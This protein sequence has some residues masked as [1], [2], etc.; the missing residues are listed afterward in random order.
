MLEA[1]RA[2]DEGAF[3]DLVEPRRA[4]L[5]AHCYRMLGS[6]QDAEDVLQDAMLRIWRG[7]P[8]FEGRSSLR[9]WM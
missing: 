7:L 3:R 1:A 5:R 9:V 2:G 8:R 6:V 4:E